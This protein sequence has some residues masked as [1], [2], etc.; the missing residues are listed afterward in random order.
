MVST[1]IYRDPVRAFVETILAEA[2]T[3]GMAPELKAEAVAALTIEAQKR[4]GLELAGAIDPDSLSQFQAVSGEATDEELTAFFALRVPDF[5]S[6][7]RK[8]LADFGAECLASSERLRANP[9]S[10]V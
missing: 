4:I 5:E 3:A 2:G 9:P 6:R 7:V 1:H 8:A 10:E